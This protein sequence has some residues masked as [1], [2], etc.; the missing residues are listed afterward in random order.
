MPPKIGG[1][2][3]SIENIQRANYSKLEIM[4]VGSLEHRL[5]ALLERGMLQP[6]P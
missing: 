1:Y 2:R 6:I 5:K 3:E 4:T